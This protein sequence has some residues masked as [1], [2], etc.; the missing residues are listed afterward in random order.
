MVTIRETGKGDISLLA[1]I[2][3]DAYDRPQDGENWSLKQAEA[4]L[5]FYFDQKTFIGFTAFVDSKVVGAFFSSVKPWHDGNRLGEGELFV[6]PKYQN[7]KIGTELMYKM[8]KSAE[9]RGCLVHEL[10]AYNK[11]AEWYKSLGMKESGLHH[12]EGKVTEI[13]ERLLR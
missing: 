7:Q 6:D 9:Q 4:L 8:M 12:M 3:R 1:R 10:L 13:K 2:Y 5:N 11:I